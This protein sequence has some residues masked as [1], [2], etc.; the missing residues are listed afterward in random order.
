MCVCVY[1][2]ARM[3]RGGGVR[4]LVVYDCNVMGVGATR[5]FVCVFVCVC[6]WGGGWLCTTA[7]QV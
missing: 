3:G 7:D 5:E 2:C 4:G 6:V 1:V